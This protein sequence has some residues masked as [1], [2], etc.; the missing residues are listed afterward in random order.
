[1]HAVRGEG[2]TSVGAR[3]TRATNKM[4]AGLM[5]YATRGAPEARA[6][7]TARAR[8]SAVVRAAETSPS[9]NFD[10]RDA[11]RRADEARVLASEISAIATASG[12]KG[13]TRT[14]RAIESLGKLALSY[15]AELDL[16][17]PP[18]APEVVRRTFEALGATYVKLGQFVAS[19]PSVFPKEYVDEFQKCLDETPVTDFSVIKRTIERDLGRSIDD[20]FAT[21]DPVPLAS[22]S[23]AQVHRATLLA[24]NKDVVVKVVKPDVEDALTADLSFILVVSKVLQFLNPELART[25]LVDI[26]GDI[27]ASMLE[28]VDLRKE[29]ANIDAF[30]RYLEDTQLT[31]LAKAPYVYKQFSNKRVM[32]M[33]YLKGVPLT[34]LDAIRGVS[35]SPEETLVNA[36]NVWF[37]S[38]LACESFHADVHAGNLLVCD[39]GKIGFIDFGIVGRVSGSTWGAIQT[40]FQSAASRDY[41]KMAL[42]LITM[43]AADDAVDVDKFARDLRKVYEAIDAIEPA[44]TVQEDG[45]SGAVTVDQQEVAQLATELIRVGDENG[46]KFPREFGL[47]LKQILYFDRYVTLLAPE[48]EV[49]SD[50][51]IEFMDAVAVDVQPKRLA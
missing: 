21:I 22:A 13:A 33:E 44:I 47:L 23:V 2:A 45:M 3:A 27:R 34:D 14:F 39:D 19:A 49:M 8:R 5:T 42:A 10:A 38:V 51:R 41:Q 35:D 26:V 37:G 48:L 29:A 50:E 43:G 25:S 16:N 9:S 12:A 32:V 28:E 7:V 30:T 24:G 20:V 15:T 40:F 46:V 1:M 31:S 17:N 11:L 36:L 6:R 18:S 4:R